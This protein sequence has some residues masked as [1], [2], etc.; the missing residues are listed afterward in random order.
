MFPSGGHPRLP[1]A[2]HPTGPGQPWVWDP[3]AG[4]RALPLRVGPPPQP[5]HTEDPEKLLQLGLLS[6]PVCVSCSSRARLRWVIW[7]L[8]ALLP[9]RGRQVLPVLHLPQHGRVHLHGLQRPLHVPE[10]RA[11]DHPQRPGKDGGGGGGGARRG[12][13]VPSTPRCQPRPPRALGHAPNSSGSVWC[14]VHPAWISG[15]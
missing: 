8:C 3:P 10:S 1:A 12:P 13:A 9:F 15:C 5:L 6:G 2:A 4:L 11:A 7:L 14:P